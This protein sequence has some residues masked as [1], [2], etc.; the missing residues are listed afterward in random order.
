M[1]TDP[2]SIQ[3]DLTP[4]FQRDLRDLAKR[5]RRVRS[6]L[7]PLIE[8]LQAGE[9][10]GD[11]ISGVTYTVFKVRLKNSNVQK[12]K[13]GGYRVIYY[14]KADDRII[15]ATIYSKSDFADVAAEVIENAIAQYEQQTQLPDNIS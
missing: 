4:R 12:G 9:L 13:S 7:Q 10:P 15:L 2:P 1:Q 3:I 14:I 5:Y 11:R 6:D 8:Q